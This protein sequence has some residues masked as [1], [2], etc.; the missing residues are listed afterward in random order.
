[1][2]E[3]DTVP[4]EISA[5]NAGVGCTILL[6]GNMTSFPQATFAEPLPIE[7]ALL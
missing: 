1:M 7:P 3:T 5:L 4:S 2:A 6:T